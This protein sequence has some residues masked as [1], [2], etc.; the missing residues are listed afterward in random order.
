MM[1]GLFSNLNNKVNEILKEES[2]FIT[3]VK[4][5][6]EDKQVQIPIN[7]EMILYILKKQEIEGISNLDVTITDDLMKISGIAK[8]MLLSIDFSFDLK[9]KSTSGRVIT[10][11]VVGMKPLNQEWIKNRVFN[12]PKVLSY[13]SNCISIDINEIESIKN[14]PVGKIKGFS[15]K[16]NKLLVGL[17]V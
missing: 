13:H 8:K 15:I 9:P 11:E 3:Q 17:G 12:K 10:F 16:D 4:N 7:S 6:I 1:K 2:S 5:K 14:I